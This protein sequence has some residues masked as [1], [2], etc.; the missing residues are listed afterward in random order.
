MLRG[1]SV[2]LDG[3]F[4]EILSETAIRRVRNT[5]ELDDGRLQLPGMATNA[6]A[7]LLFLVQ[8]VGFIPI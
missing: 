3:S 2:D 6:L 7:L 8:W 5:V 4:E 1:G